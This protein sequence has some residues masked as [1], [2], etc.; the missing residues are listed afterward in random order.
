MADLQLVFHNT[1]VLVFYT[2]TIDASADYY[3]IQYNFL[4][5]FLIQEQFDSR[6]NKNLRISNCAKT[7]QCKYYV[8]PA[9]GHMFSRF[10]SYPATVIPAGSTL[11]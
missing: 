2:P 5:H 4:S 7:A 8:R 1:P 10:K 6:L 3:K 9:K 11:E